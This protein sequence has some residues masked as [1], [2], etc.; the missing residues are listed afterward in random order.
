MKSN[1]RLLTGAALSKK[2]APMRLNLIELNLC[3]S[4]ESFAPIVAQT[5]VKL[6]SHV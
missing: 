3:Q 2:A 5:R 6:V 4:N 1:F